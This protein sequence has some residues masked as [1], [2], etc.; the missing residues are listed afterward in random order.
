MVLHQCGLILP[1]PLCRTAG[2]SSFLHSSCR[3]VTILFFICRTAGRPSFSSFVRRVAGRLCFS[4]FVVPPGD[5]PF[6]HSSHRR[7]P[8]YNI[9]IRRAA[10]CQSIISSSF[11]PPGADPYYLHSSRRRAPIHITFLPRAAGRPSISLFPRAAGRLAK[12]NLFHFV[13]R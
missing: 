7:A 1:I 2:R 10:G 4:S 13:D 5:N 8:I 3:R 12:L 9:F 6:L 11:A